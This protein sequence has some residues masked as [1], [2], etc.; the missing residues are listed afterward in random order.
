MRSDEAR[1]SRAAT[2]LAAALTA[3]YLGLGVEIALV[4]SGFLLAPSFVVPLIFA[5]A[6]EQVLPRI[7]QVLAEGT[8]AERAE[9]WVRGGNSL[10]AAA[11]WPAGAGTTMTGTVP[12]QELV[13]T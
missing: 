3:V 9:V 8:G 7:A 4:G 1:P 6:G 10:R 2:L 5:P 11:S 13:P 12:A